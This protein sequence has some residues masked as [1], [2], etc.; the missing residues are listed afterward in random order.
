MSSS[1]EIP[2]VLQIVRRNTGSKPSIPSRSAKA[3]SGYRGVSSQGNRWRARICIDKVE[4]TIGDF[5]TEDEAAQA[6]DIEAIKRGKLKYLNFVYKGLNDKPPEQKKRKPARKRKAQA[7][8]DASV[9]SSSSKASKNDT[10]AQPPVAGS[11]LIEHTV[12]SKAA[13]PA[14]GSM[15]PPIGL[16]SSS[17][18]VVA[19]TAGVSGVLHIP[20]ETNPNLKARPK[21]RNRNGKK[22][23]RVADTSFMSADA[24]YFPAD[25]ARASGDLFDPARGYC[26]DTSVH[27]PQAALYAMPSASIAQGPALPRAPFNPYFSMANAAPN[28]AG[29]AIVNEQSQHNAPTGTCL[30]LVAPPAPPLTAWGRM[31]AQAQQ[32]AN[33]FANSSKP[34]VTTF[35]KDRAT[36]QPG[37]P[38]L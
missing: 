25:Y 5:D 34:A 21:V 11:S 4:Y 22:Y 30:P 35:G 29:A 2:S 18:K 37:G 31:S 32:L 10:G 12:A 1:L 33:A 20:R 16:A 27:E 14:D 38:D 13:G 7:G 28:K 24:R 15:P 6:Y 17:S 23:A 3:S 26:A 19:G 9:A 8:L 36:K